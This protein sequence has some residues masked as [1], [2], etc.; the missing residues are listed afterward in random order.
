MSERLMNGDL[1]VPLKLCIAFICL[2]LPRDDS[3]M[4]A[5]RKH[6]GQIG[7]VVSRA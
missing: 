3:F 5:V 4:E 7:F 1:I 6:E 2:V